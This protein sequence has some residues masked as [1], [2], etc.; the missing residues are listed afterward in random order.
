MS[1]IR[2]VTDSTADL[3]PRAD[4]LG[5]AVVPLTV[6][7]GDETFLD[8]VD[9]DARAFFERLASANAR[10]RPTTSQPTPDMFER[11]YRRLLGEGADGIVS[12]HVSSV[13][14]GT[15]D[16]AQ[17]I[18]ADLLAMGVSVPIEVIDSRQASLGMHFGILAA[19][20]AAREGADMPTAI[21]AA[22]DALART[23][24]FFVAE[25][26]EYLRRGGRIGQAQRV[27][28]TLLNVKPV[29][30]LRDGAVISLETPR[31]RR[32]AYERLA[33]LVR[34]RAPVESVIVGQSSP[35]IGD[36]L[37]AAVR[38]V[39]DG[40]L[41]RMWAGPTIGAHV[42]PGAAGLAVLRAK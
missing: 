3:G 41:T 25:D 17:R 21:A 37:E 34:E 14:S 9:L 13:L 39:Y 18:A 6:S 27:V 8:S 4:E 15:A 24:V 22:R 2:V 29:I 19:S 12:I 10:T 35:D 11:L 7:F 38:R 26:L 16:T 36:Q 5:I 32:R 30:T 31:T 28:G 20:R 33:E 40:P 42:G 23:S 1:T